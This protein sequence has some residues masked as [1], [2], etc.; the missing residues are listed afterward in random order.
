[1]DYERYREENHLKIEIADRIA[2]VTLDR[3]EKRNAIDYKLHEGLERALPQLG[4]DPD[5]GAI[6]LTGAGSA[7]CAGG[8]LTG[9]YPPGASGPSAV[10][11]NRE[12]NWA[13]ARC[14]AP[15]IAAVNGTAAGLG[16]TIA[17]M[18]DVIFMADTAMIGDTHPAVALSAGDGGQAIWPL[19]VGPHRAK[20]Y[21]MAG[22]LI[23]ASEA[24]RIGLVNHVVPAAELMPR[25]LGLRAQARRWR[26]VGDPLDQA[27]R[28]QADPAAA[29]PDA[30]ARARDRVHVHDDRGQQG[31]V[32]R[33]P[34]EAQAGLPR[35]L[36][37]GRSHLSA[38]RRAGPCR[39][40]GRRRHSAARRPRRPARI[41]APMCGSTRCEAKSSR[42]SWSLRCSSSGACVAKSTNWKPRIC[43]PLSST[44]LSGILGISPDA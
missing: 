17:L 24:D 11:R 1:M 32:R 42:S 15:L 34:R 37:A 44:R 26:A 13:I 31:G 39:S 29:Q 41:A 8:D 27:G 9:F 30:R 28:E 35:P 25:A 3:P 2:I 14:E 6:V 4:F 40:P 22:E 21:L 36:S 18:C 19:L 38:R 12:L 43:M 20:E 10:L 7:F 5:V 16:A 23:P 33:L